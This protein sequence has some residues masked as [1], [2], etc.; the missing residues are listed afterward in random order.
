[1]KKLQSYSF[2]L[3]GADGDASMKAVLGG[4][5]ANLAEMSKLGLPVPPGFTL[6]CEASVTFNSI[7]DKEMDAFGDQV[8]T[9]ITAGLVQL[10]STFEYMPLVSV[11]SGARVSMPGMMDTI[12]NVGL[13]STTLPFWTEKLGAVAALDSYRRLIQMYS[14][15]ALGIDLELF[16]QQLESMKHEANVKTDSELNEDQLGRL[17]KRYLKVV[18]DASMVFPDTMESQVLGA[19]C[20]VFKSWNNQR[21][22]EYRKI[23]K[24]PSDWGTAVTIQSMVFGNLNDDSATGVL[25]SRDPSTG[26]KAITGEF[27][28]NA[29]GE[30]VVAGIR[31]PENMVKLPEWNSDVS[32]ELFGIVAKLEHHYRDMQDIEFTV[33]DGQLFILQTRNGKRSALAEFQVAYDMANEGLI[34]TVEAADRIQPEQLFKV[35]Q[36]SI[37][38][39]FKGEPW[40]TGI[41]AG[42][43][44]VAG[45]AM[46][47]A[48]AALACSEPCILVTKET[49]PD[50]IAGMNASVGILTATGG[51]TSHAAVVARGM[52]KACVVGVTAMGF[53]TGI[54]GEAYCNGSKAFAEGDVLTIDGATGNVWVGKVPMVAGGVS[55]IIKAVVSWGSSGHSERIELTQKSTAEEIHAMVTGATGSVL[56]IDTVLMESSNHCPDHLPAIMK[57]LGDAL[58]CVDKDVVVDLAGVSH[59][60]SR[61]DIAMDKMFGVGDKTSFNIGDHKVTGL[62]LWASEVIARVTVNVPPELTP[63]SNPIKKAGFKVS[64]NAV[65]LAD[66]LNASGPMSVS[67]AI[68]T[69]VFGSEEAYTFAMNAI[70]ATGK[71]FASLPTPAHWYETITKKGALCL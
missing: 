41:A 67:P 18:E 34:T 48:E 32:A 50:D 59:S 10:A 3:S 63:L 27:L 65:T 55:P 49:N 60:Y 16:E 25:F 35:L 29:Q 13:T 69:S 54:K 39:K 19:V 70:K 7:T 66:L 61:G 20:A 40:F 1:M 51:L 21:A 11:R 56:H 15:V 45:R 58:A 24:I 31:T 26:E 43:G 9:L 64:G 57:A 68:M 2:G 5:G 44:V 62:L 42:G 52:N 71:G 30:D 46:F 47:S 17:V 23:H 4:K 36:D 22:V 53:S 14:S 28:V 38:P 37:D 33:Q 8:K 6:P 12:L